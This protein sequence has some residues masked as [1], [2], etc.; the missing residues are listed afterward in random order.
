[1]TPKE[2]NRKWP[3]YRAKLKKQFESMG[4]T[5]CEQ[6]SGTFALSFA[7]SRKRRFIT[8]EADLMEVALL[9]QK[10]HET[11]EH[12]GHEEMFET[13]NTIISS[14]AVR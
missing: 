5:R 9:C 11:A 6:C 7:H 14:R 10:C 4:I 2:R 12:S 13:I 8:T 1:M 3:T